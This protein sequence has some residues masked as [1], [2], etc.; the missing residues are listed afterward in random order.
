MGKSTLLRRGDLGKGKRLKERRDTY[1]GT[2]GEEQ[3]GT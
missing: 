2:D 3:V 1:L